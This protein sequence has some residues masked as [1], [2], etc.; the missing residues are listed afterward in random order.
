MIFHFITIGNIIKSTYEKIME[1]NI[2]GLR[3]FL[4]RKKSSTKD[5]LRNSAPTC[6]NYTQ[7]PFDIKSTIQTPLK[8]TLHM[9]FHFITMGNIVKTT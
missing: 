7:R 9:I 3:G 2:L 5:A 1:K 4:F 8:F 6:S